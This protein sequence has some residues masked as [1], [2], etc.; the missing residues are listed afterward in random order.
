V[1][2]PWTID[3]YRHVDAPVETVWEIISNHR[4]YPLW[5]TIRTARL[6]QEGRPHP[7]GVGVVRFLGVGPVGAREQVLDFDPPHHLA[8]TILSGPPV[9]GYRADMDLSPT[10]DGGTDLRWTGGFDSAPPGTAR[11]C[12]A[13][14]ERALRSMAD[15]I[16]KEGARRSAMA[17]AS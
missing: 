5:T 16:V 9:R 1:D 11:V 3:V 4:A 2:K 13:V 14:L 17:S 12:R 6:E 8:Y 15:G 10:S 7:D